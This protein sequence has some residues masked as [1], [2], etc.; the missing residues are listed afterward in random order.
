MKTQI[1]AAPAVKGF[2]CHRYGVA[3]AEFSAQIHPL[4]HGLKQVQT[5][6][7]CP[8]HKCHII[9]LFKNI[10]YEIVRVLFYPSGVMNRASDFW[11]PS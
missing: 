9:G 10:N 8:A 7:Q 3:M 1:Y 6:N 5:E 4:F 11:S 2:P